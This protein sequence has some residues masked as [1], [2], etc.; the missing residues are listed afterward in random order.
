MGL[1][2][3]PRENKDAWAAI[4]MAGNA[5]GS[6]IPEETLIAATAMFVSQHLR[7]FYES[8]EFVY[9]TKNKKTKTSRFELAKKHH[10]ELLRVKKYYDKAQK[11]VIS[12]AT[13]AYVALEDFYKH[14]HRAEALAKQA[15]RQRQKDEFWETYGFMEFVDDWIDDINNK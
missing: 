10:V 15:E 1:F 11:K 9:S 7:I 2:G 14:P 8:V 12:Q 6:M 5:P 3:N 4:V 13:D